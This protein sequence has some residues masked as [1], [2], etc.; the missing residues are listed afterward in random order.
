V[1]ALWSHGGWPRRLMVCGFFLLSLFSCLSLRFAARHA[2]DNYRDA[3]AYARAALQSGQQVW[4][5]ADSQGAAYY[6]VPTADRPAEIGK[7]WLVRN[8]SRELLSVAPMPEVIISSKPDIFDNQ[9]ALAEY[10][11]QAGFTKAATL[12]AFT[13]WQRST[14]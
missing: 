5:N 14:N 9:R 4:W 1:E 7:A 3:A 8:P 10:I 13:I 11:V 2:K 12:S 6:E